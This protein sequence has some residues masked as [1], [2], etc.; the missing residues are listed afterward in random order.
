MS[1]YFLNTVRT[2]RSIIRISLCIACHT[3]TFHICILILQLLCVIKVG[4]VTFLLKRCPIPTTLP[5]SSTTFSPCG[6]PT[7]LSFW[8]SRAARQGAGSSCNRHQQ[9]HVWERTSGQTVPP[10]QKETWEQPPFFLFLNTVAS[11]RVP[12]S[13]TTIFSPWP[14]QAPRND[15]RAWVPSL[16]LQPWLP[17]SLW[18][19]PWGQEGF[20]YL[21]PF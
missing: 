7:F 10:L 12:A 1:F 5:P 18:L 3:V 19:L 17:L 13:A 8:G 4:T 2:Q 21:D 9:D 11:P 6:R 14:Q 16:S 20:C 15:G